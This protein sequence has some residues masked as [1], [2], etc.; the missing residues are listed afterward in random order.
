MLKS[1]RWKSVY[2]HSL[3]NNVPTIKSALEELMVIG[4]FKVTLETQVTKVEFSITGKA[5]KRKQGH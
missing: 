1:A 3:R 4:I 2:A 5:Y